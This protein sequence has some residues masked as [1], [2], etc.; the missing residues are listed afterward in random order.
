[1]NER[2][3]M[4]ADPAPRG[5]AMRLAA[6]PLLVAAVGVSLLSALS[7]GPLDALAGLPMLLLSLVLVLGGSAGVETLVRLAEARD[8][9]RRGATPVRRRFRLFSRHAPA[10]RLLVAG[11]P[12]R[13]PPAALTA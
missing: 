6:L 13:G 11:R 4:Q 9:R 3:E 12:L 5:R 10:L 8:S 7:G 2:H 1:M